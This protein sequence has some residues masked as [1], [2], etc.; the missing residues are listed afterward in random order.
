MSL[1]MRSGDTLEGVYG[2]SPNRL[3]VHMAGVKMI[4]REEGRLCVVGYA[5]SR[6]ELEDQI[7][8]LMEART[9]RRNG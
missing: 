4:L 6:V 9:A 8:H 5:D 7:A 1:L 2:I 3:M